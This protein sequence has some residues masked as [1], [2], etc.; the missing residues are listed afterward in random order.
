MS[1]TIKAKAYVLQQDNRS[2]DYLPE[3]LPREQV[4]KEWSYAIRYG[5]DGLDKPNYENAVKL[6][7]ERN[8]TWNASLCYK[9]PLTYNP[10]QADS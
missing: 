3:E 8:P 5:A 6:M 10:Q 9:N 7:L 2:G 4:Q 1:E